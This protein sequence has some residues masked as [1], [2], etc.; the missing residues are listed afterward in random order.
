MESAS[1]ETA[2]F[3]FVPPRVCILTEA[4]Y[5]PTIG[6]QEMHLHELAASLLAKGAAVMV[7]TRQTAP[8]AEARETVDGLPV[9]RVPPGGQL[10]GRGWRAIVPLMRFLLQTFRILLR[11][12]KNFDVTLVSGIKILPL[13]AVAAGGLFGKGCVI[14]P[15]SSIEFAEAISDMS[16]KQM[17]LNRWSWLI[18]VLKFVRYRTAQKADCIVAISPEIEQALQ[19]AGIKKQAIRQIANGIDLGKFCPAGEEKKFLLRDQLGLPRDKMIFL[20]SGRLAVSKGMLELIR[21]WQK[22][23]QKNAD[24]L[25]V[26]A[27]SGAGCFDDCEPQLRQAIAEAGLQHSVRL[28]GMTANVTDYLQAADVFVFPSHYEGFGLSIVEAMSCGLPLI[29]TRVGVAA[30]IFENER[31]GALVEPGNESQLERAI[32]WMLDRR[33]DWTVMGER[34][35]GPVQRRFSIAFEAEQYLDAFAAVCRRR[36]GRTRVPIQAP[37]REAA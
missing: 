37:D 13:V 32:A 12:R 22:A 19:A 30:E 23:A 20:Y 18:R 10:K 17:R 3:S 28:K 26:L 21:A 9:I 16:R 6:G 8:P 15:E 1:T 11:E 24:I 5:P 34:A 7:V 35:R 36:G 33:S 27:G 25:L 4:F 29:V 14:R 31:M 2:A